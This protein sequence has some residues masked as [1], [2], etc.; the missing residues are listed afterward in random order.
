MAMSC[1]NDSSLGTLP[2]CHECKRYISTSIISASSSGRYAVR[3]LES[4]LS[5]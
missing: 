3:R 4:S 2:T 1:L 5:R